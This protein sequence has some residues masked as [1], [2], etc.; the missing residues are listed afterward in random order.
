MLTLP[1]PYLTFDGTPHALSRI[2]SADAS[3]VRL[4]FAGP[5]P[6]LRDRVQYV[7]DDGAK[8]EPVRASSGAAGAWSG[9]SAVVRSESPME[10][11]LIW[12]QRCGVYCGRPQ[13][14]CRVGGTLTCQLITKRSGSAFPLWVTISPS[15]LEVVDGWPEST[16]AGVSCFHSLL[17][18]CAA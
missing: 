11:P 14:H 2:E 15:V 9:G 13:I 16:Q 10:Y 5:A 3:R 7:L 12:V 18:S 8:R 4:V 6:K 17:R 1:L